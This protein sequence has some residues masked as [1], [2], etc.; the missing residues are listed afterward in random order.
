MQKD[1]NVVELEKCCQTHIFLQNFVLIQPK[2]SP[3]KI[4]KIL[5]IV[6]ATNALS[7]KYP[8][9]PAAARSSAGGSQHLKVASE[10]I[11]APG[12]PS[13]LR[14]GPRLDLGRIDADLGEMYS[15]FQHFKRH[16]SK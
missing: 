5:L 1:A 10:H 3:L 6:S 15:I 13:Q 12:A 4:C 16:P 7:A 14:I 2:T 11:P 9:P 8:K